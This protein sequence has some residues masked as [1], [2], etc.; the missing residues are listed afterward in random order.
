MTRCPRRAA[1]FDLGHR[2]QTGRLIDVCDRDLR[3]T[4]SWPG[5]QLGRTL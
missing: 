1:R 3:V 5:N 2:V 4:E